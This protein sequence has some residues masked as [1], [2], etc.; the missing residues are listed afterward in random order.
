MAYRIRYSDISFTKKPIKNAR[1]FYKW[2]TIMAVI[3]ASVYMLQLEAVQ[4]FLIPG[5]PEITKSAF[6]SFTKELREGERF[7]DAVAVFCREVIESERVE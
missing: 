7:S 5:D 4:N 2:I 6:A 3:V 1:P